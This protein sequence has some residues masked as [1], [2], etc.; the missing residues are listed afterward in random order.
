MLHSR[1]NEKARLLASIFL[2]SK[3]DWIITLFDIKESFHGTSHPCKKKGKKTRRN[4]C[5]EALNDGLYH[6][7]KNSE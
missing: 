6:H 3:R 1:D 5:I 2:S 7:L 4:Q